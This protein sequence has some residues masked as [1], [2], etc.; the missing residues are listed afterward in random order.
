MHPLMAQSGASANQGGPILASALVGV[1]CFLLAWFVHRALTTEDLEQGREWRFDVTRINE[2]RSADFLF[3]C[4]QPLIELL[5]RFNLA[6]F[7]DRLP[8][9]QRQIHA[10]GFS[11]FW[12]PEEYLAKAQLMALLS[13]PFYVYLFYTFG[14]TEA[15]ILVPGMVLL[16]AWFLRR[17][18]ASQA[19]YRLV[20]IKRRMPFLLDLLT[21]LMEAG[22]T[23]LDSLAQ[24]V[25][26]LQGH[27][28]AVEFGRVLSDMSMGKTRTEAL[29]ALRARLN[30][31]DVTSVV[32][33]IIQGEE[34]G[35]PLAMIFRTQADVLRMKRTQRAET[36]AGEAGVNM[37]LPGILVMASTALIIL[38]PFVLNYLY[39][40]FSL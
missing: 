17:R 11:R 5:A 35:T 14:G 21:L 34:L 20:L 9:I 36:I 33:S 19:R 37:L 40:G 7:R 22:A 2:L 25:E 26:E 39:S 13:M 23:F 28:V 31:D 12:L 30:D 10:A 8:E 16:T 6:V 27:P 38:G 29:E 3:R 18:L 24:S 15:L 4:F 1:G 32:G